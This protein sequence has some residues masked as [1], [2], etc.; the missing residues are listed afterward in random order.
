MVSLSNYDTLFIVHFVYQHEFF[1]INF[2]HQKPD[3]QKI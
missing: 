1:R 2:Y 3:L